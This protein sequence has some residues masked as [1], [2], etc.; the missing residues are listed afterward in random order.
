MGSSTMSSFVDF[1]RL[2]S[3][4]GIVGLSTEDVL[5]L[6]K[7]FSYSEMMGFSLVSS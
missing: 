1:V 4:N 6:S 5:G 7:I 3:V 2:Y